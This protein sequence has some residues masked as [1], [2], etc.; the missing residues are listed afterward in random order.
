VQQVT[1]DDA[2]EQ[3]GFAQYSSRY[4]SV[5]R[6]QNLQMARLTDEEIKAGQ[7]SYLKVENGQPVLYL[8]E[9]FKIEY[10]HAVT[11]TQTN[12]QTGN[13]KP[14]LCAGRITSGPLAGAVAGTWQVKQLV[15]YCSDH[16]IMPPIYQP[17]VF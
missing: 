11:E 1:Y 12:P 14:W 10:V 2:G 5:F 13:K 6:S 16:S 7:K 15:V 4:A 3:P 17:G 8:T 9:D